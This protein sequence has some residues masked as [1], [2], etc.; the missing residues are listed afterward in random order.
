MNFKL[1]NYQ[2]NRCLLI[3]LVPLLFSCEKIF[4]EDDEYLVLDNYH[5]KIDMVNGIYANLVK[6]HNQNYFALF[7]RGDDINAYYRNSAFGENCPR[8]NP[9]DYNLIIGNIYKYLYTAIMNANSLILQASEGENPELLGETY[10][11]RAYCYFKLARFF[12][13]PPLV[14]DID[15]NYNIKKPGYREVYEFIESDLL[16][17]L[18]LLPATY[19]GC[20]VL[21]E[22]PHKGSAKALLAEVY[23]SMAGYPVGDSAKYRQAAL[24][25]GEVIENSGYYGI[26]LMDDFAGLWREEYR[27]N[28]E[29]IIGLFFNINEERPRVKPSSVDWYDVQ[30]T[31][32]TFFSRGNY[33]LAAF[34][35][36]KTFPEN[37]RKLV[38]MT[39]GRYIYRD[40]PMLDTNN[41]I[42]YF[43]EYDLFAD[44][45]GYIGHFQVLKWIDQTE[46][47]N[48]Y[49]FSYDIRQG[50][51]LNYPY[52]NRYGEV[53]NT[54]Y[55][56]RY[57]Q[58]L[59]TYA[60]AKGRLGEPDEP[61]Y[62]AV[63]MIRRRANRLDINSPSPYDLQPGLTAAQFT[64]SV[65]W[66]RA[67][68]LFYEPDGRWF[69]IVRL[70]LKDK[71]PENTDSLD[72]PTVI[73]DI[74]LTN[75]WYFYKIPQ[76]DRWLNPNLEYDE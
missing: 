57:A 20:R 47:E 68:E 40:F 17:A 5:E 36:F 31:K 74:F 75:D 28:P 51:L 12:G 54:I 60:E 42:L 19:T 58:T 59:L 44:R 45:C 63:N 34:K 24:L 9:P 39:T 8:G 43:Y 48:R 37:Y 14:K 4:H 64:D 70:D 18:E 53:Y 62:R 55:L 2:I 38:S 1:N 49:D 46:F 21:N 25:A 69:D 32:N 65:V 72:I 33:N 13:R 10:F 11:L 16:K 76:E 22:T 7:C 67:W 61:A 35:Y 52:S 26:S 71:L 29:N 23:L 50:R 15:V 41:R 66:E 6:I 3:M 27:H 30:T 73:D 56:L